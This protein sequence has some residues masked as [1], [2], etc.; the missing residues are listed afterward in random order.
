MS[1]QS[2][3]YYTVQ[4]DGCPQMCEHTPNFMQD[5]PGAALTHAHRNGWV[6][7]N[8]RNLCPTCRRNPSVTS[9]NDGEDNR[10]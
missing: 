3:T 1:V 8:G 6:T 9:V 2:V 7:R 4:C 10:G 5:T